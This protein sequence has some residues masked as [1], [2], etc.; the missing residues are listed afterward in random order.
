MIKSLERYA[1]VIV[2]TDEENPMPIATITD[3]TVEVA[4]GY[5]VRLTPY[6][7][8]PET[9]EMKSVRD[10]LKEYKTCELV[11]ELK[12]REGVEARQAEPY[13]DLEIKVNGPAIVLVIID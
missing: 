6:I 1:K 13:K 12:K 8:V 2:E 11:E 3:D 7:F 4:D 5:R 9:R 10:K